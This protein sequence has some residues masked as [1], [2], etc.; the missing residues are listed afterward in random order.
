MVRCCLE[1][2]TKCFLQEAQRNESN[3][4]LRGRFRKQITHK[5]KER[6]KNQNPKPL[7]LKKREKTN[8]G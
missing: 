1:A 5:Q 4:E 8:K 2:K 3:R 7:T 6:K